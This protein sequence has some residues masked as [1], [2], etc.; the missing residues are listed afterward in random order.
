MKINRRDSLRLLGAGTLGILAGPLRGNTAKA[1]HMVTLSFDDGFEKSSIKTAEIYEKYG[2]SACINVIATGHLGGSDD[3]YQD[4]PMG[5]FSLWNEL[6]KRGHEIMPH[7]YRHAKLTKMPL[8]EAE[9]LVQKCMDVFDKELDGY[10]SDASVYNCAYNASSPELE[11]WLKTKFRAIRTGWGHFNPLPHEGQFRLTCSLNGP[12]N[13]DKPLLKAVD[14]FLE[15]P[16][17]WMI[18]NAHGLDEEGWG[19]MSSVFLDELLGRLKEIDH[20]RVLPVIPALD[21]V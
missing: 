2:L 4:W 15:G 10:A 3:E 1:S 21:S 19:P 16:S 11:A 5:D 14:E 7:S 17:G 20:V 13:I 9:G 8:K 18:Y 12:D 6:K